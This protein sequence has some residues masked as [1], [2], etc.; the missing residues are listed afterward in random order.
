RLYVTGGSDNL[1]NEYRNFSK[2]LK[3][4]DDGYIEDATMIAEM[5]LKEGSLNLPEIYPHRTGKVTALG[6]TAFKFVDNTMDFDLNER[7]ETNNTVYL[8]QGTSAKVH[9]NTG[10]L[11]GYEFE[12]KKNGYS[13]DKKEFEIIPF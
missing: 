6:T 12:I 9:F 5:G 4:S 10:N 3:F 11:A 8:I 7:D 1:P 13:H 2:S